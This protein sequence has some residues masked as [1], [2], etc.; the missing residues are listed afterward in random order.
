MSSGGLERGWVVWRKIV[1]S[2]R[3]RKWGYFEIYK[4]RIGWRMIILWD[5]TR[6]DDIR[7]KMG[8]RSYGYRIRK[9]D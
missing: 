8:L 9:E 4:S 7:E 5:L 3:K 2:M 1:G 6:V